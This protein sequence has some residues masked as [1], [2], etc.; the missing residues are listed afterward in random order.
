MGIEHLWEFRLVRIVSGLDIKFRVL[1]K[2]PFRDENEHS[3]W[4]SGGQELLRGVFPRIYD[5][6]EGDPHGSLST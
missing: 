3:K 5:S 6:A 1:R 4:L 2:H